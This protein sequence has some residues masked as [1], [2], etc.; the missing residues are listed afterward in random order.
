MSQLTLF[1]VAFLLILV[2]LLFM[3]SLYN[4]DERELHIFFTAM[5]II[6]TSIITCIVVFTYYV[7]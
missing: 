4:S 6:L 2:I 7:H 5:I 1:F 3:G